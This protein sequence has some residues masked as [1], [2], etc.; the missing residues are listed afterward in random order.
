MH[1]YSIWQTVDVFLNVRHSCL[2]CSS[3]SDS[4]FACLRINGAKDWKGKSQLTDLCAAMIQGS[5]Y[6]RWQ[7]SCLEA[8]VRAAHAVVSCYDVAMLCCDLLV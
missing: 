3:F 2:D 4:C 8:A 1:V 7:L 6:V 5:V